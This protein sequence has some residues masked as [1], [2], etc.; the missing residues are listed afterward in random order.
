MG[1]HEDGSNAANFEQPENGVLPVFD[2]HPTVGRAA[3]RGR[4]HC[5]SVAWGLQLVKSMQYKHIYS[6]QVP[7]KMYTLI[8]TRFFGITLSHSIVD[9]HHEKGHLEELIS[10]ES[11]WGVFL[12][13]KL[14]KHV[15]STA[16]YFQT[17]LGQ[18]TTSP[19]TSE[20]AVAE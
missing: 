1:A 17:C 16:W 9:V 14:G 2:V 18:V 4:V 5:P 20:Y 10:R 15:W 7:Q 6:L 19:A 11:R 8:D 3:V 13:M 12:G